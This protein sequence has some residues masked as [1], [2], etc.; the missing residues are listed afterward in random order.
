MEEIK[1]IPEK[2]LTLSEEKKEAFLKDERKDARL[3]IVFFS[4]FA[5]F[6]LLGLHSLIVGSPYYP[7]TDLNTFLFTFTLYPDS[8][9]IL[10]AVLGILNIFCVITRIQIHD[11][12]SERQIPVDLRLTFY[13]RTNNAFKTLLGITFILDIFLFIVFT[14]LTHAITLLVVLIV[15]IFVYSRWKAIHNKLKSILEE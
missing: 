8:I 6:C 15:T 3:Y 5:G 2:Y 13:I 7:S 1:N 4:L 10:F 11:K 14:L 12:I 9:V